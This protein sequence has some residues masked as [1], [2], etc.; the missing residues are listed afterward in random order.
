MESVLI[1]HVEGTLTITAY[2]LDV[3]GGFDAIGGEQ[4]D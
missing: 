3:R 2:E 1:G 4:I